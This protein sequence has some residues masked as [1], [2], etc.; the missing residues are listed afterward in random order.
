MKLQ[1]SYAVLPELASDYGQDP[2]E[3]RNSAVESIQ[4]VCDSSM[5]ASASDQVQCAVLL[6]YL[7]ADFEKYTTRT[8][9]LQDEFE[10]LYINGK[11]LQAE[12]GL[13]KTPVGDLVRLKQY[14]LLGK[15]ERAS[16]LHQKLKE[17]AS[18]S[19]G[20]QVFFVITFLAVL[21]IGFSF[22]VA[23]IRKKPVQQFGIALLSV[24]AGHFRVFL[25]ATILTFFGIAALL[26]LLGG[27]I[28][29]S[30]RMYGIVGLHFLLLVGVLVYVA[31]QSSVETLQKV[32]GDWHYRPGHQL[33]IGF[34]G[35]CAIVPVGLMSAMVLIQQA[36]SDPVEQAHPIA[37]VLQDHF[38]AAFI[39]AVVL[40][41]LMEEIVFRGFLYGYLRSRFSIL[42]AAPL[43]GLVFAILHPQGV[44]AMPYLFML[45]TGLCLLREYNRSLVPAIFAHMVTNGLVM[46][47]SYSMMA[48]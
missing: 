19:Y 15:E 8:G 25:E 2:T 12:A 10:T 48:S 4:Q 38:L 46:V 26:P 34:L 43:T 11:P 18:R 29:E 31:R 16:E 27:L 1:V 40:A 20:L 5:A 17:Q 9:P 37:F 33:L 21:V 24:P 44:A 30:M 45:G 22:A 6:A 41:P 39:L 7:Q 13:F 3:A 23:A 35:W 32:F 28:P 47:I 42:A 36:A 14:R